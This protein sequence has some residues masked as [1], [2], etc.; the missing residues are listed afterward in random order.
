ME[1]LIV[2]F[3]LYT[4]LWV[5]ITAYLGI[6]IQKKATEIKDTMAGYAKLAA[7]YLRK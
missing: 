5:G 2:L 1:T 4:I 7:Q 3:V 6:M